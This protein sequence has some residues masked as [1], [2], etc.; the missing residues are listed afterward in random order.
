MNKPR[1]NNGIIMGVSKRKASSSVILRCFRV[2]QSRKNPVLVSEIPMAHTL[3]VKDAM[4]CLIKLGL[5][6]KVEMV[7]SNG[8][9]KGNRKGIKGYVLRR[10]N[11]N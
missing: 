8:R 11:E 1:T 4:H 5:V 6:E 7:Y 3:I 2:L 10:R 9:Y